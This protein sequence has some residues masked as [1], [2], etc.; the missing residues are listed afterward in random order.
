MPHR[1]RMQVAA[2][3]MPIP[4][5]IATLCIPMGSRAQQSVARDPLPSW[6]DGHAKLAILGFVREVTDKSG[7]RY[8]KPEDRIATFDDDGTLWSEWPRHVNQ[9]QMVFA[10]QRFAAGGKNPFLNLLIRHDDAKR[11]FAY[12]EGTSKVLQAARARG[13]TTVSMKNDFRVVFSFRAE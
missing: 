4:L 2:R 10:R 12:D 8:V 5:L 9:I 3:L 11:E 6:Q 13:W 7:P 1:I